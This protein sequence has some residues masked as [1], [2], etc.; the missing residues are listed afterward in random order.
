MARLRRIVHPTDF[1]PASG[2]AF[3]KAV[4]QAKDNKASLA[5]V[6]VLLIKPNEA[7]AERQALEAG[8]KKCPQ[9]AE[10]VKEQAKVCRF[11]GHEFPEARQPV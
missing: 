6:H 10:I 4:E 2:P 11:C 9:C 5:I 7:H 8:G 3:K 1:S